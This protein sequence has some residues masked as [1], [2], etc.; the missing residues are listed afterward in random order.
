ML[1]RGRS[2]RVV[3]CGVV[4]S[5]FRGPE[6]LA[7]SESLVDPAERVFAHMIVPTEVVKIFRG[8]LSAVIRSCPEHTV[9][10]NKTLIQERRS[11]LGQ[12]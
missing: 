2:G 4:V 5:E 12:K 9:T 1:I 7:V 6:V 3:A 11:F 8:G 10:E